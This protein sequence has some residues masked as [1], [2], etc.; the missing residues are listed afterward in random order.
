MPS[1]A[2][3]TP[4]SP[5]RRH[6]RALLKTGAMLTDDA[7]LASAGSTP[8][9][10]AASATNSKLASVASATNGAVTASA[11]M[12]WS[13]DKDDGAMGGGGAA[14]AA[15]AYP[16]FSNATPA[17]PADQPAAAAPATAAA[18]TGGARRRLR[19]ASPGGKALI[20]TDDQIGD[21]FQWSMDKQGPA[22]I[23]AATGAAATAVTVGQPLAPIDM[24]GAAA[25][26]ALAP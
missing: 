12:A 20:S 22:A 16:D 9:G 13:F 25:R 10:G 15:P 21:K 18:P 14:V 7:A 24:D 23:G 4:S 19:S 17:G 2:A 26:A 3:A 11:T 1:A 5:L 6:R 8:A